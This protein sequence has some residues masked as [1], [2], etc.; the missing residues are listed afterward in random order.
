FWSAYA[1][2]WAPHSDVPFPA[3]DASV[4]TWLAAAKQERDYILHLLRTFGHSHEIVQLLAPQVLD[5]LTSPWRDE[6]W[7]TAIEAGQQDEKTDP[8]RVRRLAQW[9]LRTER[10]VDNKRRKA[11]MTSTDEWDVEI[12]ENYGRDV[13]MWL[14]APSRT[15]RLS[16]YILFAHIYAEK[17]A[18]MIGEDSH[19]DDSAQTKLQRHLTALRK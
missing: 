11:I 10:A 13:V 19:P 12:A 15:S 1:G 9:G 2:E 8:T 6:C 16:N 14:C 3:V 4:E 7:Q 17:V 5:E 18:A